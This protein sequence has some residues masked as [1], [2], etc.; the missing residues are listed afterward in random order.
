MR[1]GQSRIA[2]SSFFQN[3]MGGD[4]SRAILFGIFRGFSL[5]F[6]LCYCFQGSGTRA[7]H[8]LPVI[9]PSHISHE[10]NGT[11]K[12]C[13]LTLLVEKESGRKRA[14]L[15]TYMYVF[16]GQL[17]VNHV[18][19]STCLAV[20]LWVVSLH[21]IL[22]VKLFPSVKFMEKLIPIDNVLQWSCELTSVTNANPLHLPELQLS[23]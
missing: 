9:L 15:A 2:L 12:V 21:N 23:L 14:L 3:L 7:G 11:Q 19:S 22:L 20:G 8:A 1:R 13:R 10:V 16:W 18:S 4:T 6:C 17:T 5:L